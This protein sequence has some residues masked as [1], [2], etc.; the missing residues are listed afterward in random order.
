MFNRLLL[1]TA[2]LFVALPTQ[3]CDVC[4][5]SVSGYGAGLLSAYRYNTIGWRWYESPFK[6][7]LDQGI[8]TEDNFQ[9]LDVSLRYHLGT[10]WI[11]G[12]NQAYQWNHR[13]GPDRSLTLDGIGDTRLMASYVLLD[14]ILVGTK[15]QLYWEL[16][17][18]VKLPT[19]SF[20]DDLYQD[21]L[22]ENFNIGNGSWAYL[23]QT[24]LVYNYSKMGWVLNGSY[25]AN[26][27][28]K[29][30]YHFGNQF[31]LSTLIFARQSIGEK[32]ELIPFLGLFHEQISSDKFYQ[33]NGAHG[34]GGEGTFWTMGLNAKY[35]D[36]LLGVSYF[37]AFQQS[38]AE[39]EMEAKPRFSLELTYSF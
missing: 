2:L 37:Q 6:Q 22:P 28:T 34:T 24:S 9:L 12:V 33:D 29:D 36:Y 19:G 15:G 16:G 35:L 10:R 31:S 1:F 20:N 5:C 18:G 39:G 17:S 21:D 32:A 14:N 4:G 38:Y 8:A 11:L 13:Q 23:L 7:N 30:D 3:A 25:Q 26:G 27:R